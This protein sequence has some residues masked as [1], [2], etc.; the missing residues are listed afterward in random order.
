MVYEVTDLGGE[1]KTGHGDK[2]NT[3]YCKKLIDRC[4]TREMI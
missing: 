3:E 4:I 1:E 2:A